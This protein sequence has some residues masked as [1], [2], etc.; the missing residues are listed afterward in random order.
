MIQDPNN[1]ANTIANPA[2]VANPY[3]ALGNL[4]YVLPNV[5]NLGFFNENFSLSKSQSFHDRYILN[6]GFDLLD[7]FNRRDFGG[8]NTTL[9]QAGFGQYTTNGDGPRIIQIHSKI[10]F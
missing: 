6:I 3:S 5:R 10:T 1:P 2:V 4:K 7:A 8:L 9:G